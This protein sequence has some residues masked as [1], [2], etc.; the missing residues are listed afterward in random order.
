MAGHRLLPCVA[1]DCIL[2]VTMRIV[3]AYAA[4]FV[5]IGGSPLRMVRLRAGA[6]DA[7]NAL[8]AA[9]AGCGCICSLSRSSPRN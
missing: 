7:F 3:L 5:G 9:G 1:G 6:R 2:L 4:V 8:L